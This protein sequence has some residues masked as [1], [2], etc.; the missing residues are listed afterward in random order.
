M[1][2][3]DEK[4]GFGAWGMG[5]DSGPGVVAACA[6]APQINTSTVAVTKALRRRERIA[7]N[8]QG[9]VPAMT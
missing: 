5:V 6:T 1:N 3:I 7:S 8:L 9:G 2:F 4:S